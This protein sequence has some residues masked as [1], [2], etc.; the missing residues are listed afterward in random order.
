MKK[1]THNADTPFR[2]KYANSRNKREIKKSRVPSAQECQESRE[3]CVRAGGLGAPRGLRAPPAHLEAKAGSGTSSR[4]TAAPGQPRLGGKTLARDNRR[5]NEEGHR[6]LFSRQLP[7]RSTAELA[8]PGAAPL[9]SPAQPRGAPG[10]SA[11]PA[12]PALRQLPARHPPA[13]RGEP[14]S[15]RL[16]PGRARRPRPLERRVFNGAEGASAPG[17][18]ATAAGSSAC[19]TARQRLP[20][21]PRSGATVLRPPGPGHRGSEK[22]ATRCPPQLPVRPLP[23][24]SPVPSRRRPAGG[25][26]PTPRRS[27]RQPRS[28]PEISAHCPPPPAGEGAPR[29]G[30]AGEEPG[31]GRPAGEPGASR[32]FPARPRPLLSLR[33]RAARTGSPDGQPWTE[34]RPPCSSSA[35]AAANRTGTERGGHNSPL[36]KKPSPGPG[37]CRL[38]AAWQSGLFSLAVWRRLASRPPG[39]KGWGSTGTGQGGRASPWGGGE[40]SAESRAGLQRGSVPVLLPE[41]RHSTSG[42]PRCLG[43]FGWFPHWLQ[44]DWKFHKVIPEYSTHRVRTEV[45]LCGSMSLSL[46]HQWREGR[47]GFTAVIQKHPK[48][49]VYNHVTRNGPLRVPFHAYKLFSRFEQHQPSSI[50]RRKVL[51]NLQGEKNHNKMW[52]I[53]AYNRKMLGSEH[54]KEKFSVWV[55]EGM[56]KLFNRRSMDRS[57][58]S[59]QIQ[60]CWRSLLKFLSE[61]LWYLLRVCENKPNWQRPLGI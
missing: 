60:Q 7:L 9:R 51:L 26:P 3:E 22:R 21:P 49:S 45:P 14:P 55:M 37:Y 50:V 48:T 34:G 58:S 17:A 41:R 2:K 52:Y 32:R 30:R 29:P 24:S 6:S 59:P 35:R 19:S 12:R 31:W 57:T 5:A 39:G 10:G 11:A 46:I 23:F 33:E 4:G 54:E 38:E 53:L 61:L 36:K 25:S 44:L 28:P 20:C 43:H 1:N 13:V 15:S 16:T 27:L 40:G 47:W 18:P 8:R 56:S 42:T